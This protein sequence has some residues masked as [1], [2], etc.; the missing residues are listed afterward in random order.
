MGSCVPILVTD[1]IPKRKTIWEVE[2]EDDNASSKADLD[3]EYNPDFNEYDIMSPR[4]HTETYFSQD[5]KLASSPVRNQV[6]PYFYHF[7]S[8]KSFIKYDDTH[9]DANIFLSNVMQEAE[10]KMIIFLWRWESFH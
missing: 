7:E 5:L 10:E 4:Q 6:T 1:K 2:N 9:P 3:V 8:Y